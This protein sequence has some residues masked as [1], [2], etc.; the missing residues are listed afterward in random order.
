NVY[1]SGGRYDLATAAYEQSLSIDNKQIES[2]F[3]LGKLLYQVDAFDAATKYY[4]QALI[5]ADEY[6][7]LPSD[8]LLELLA[9]VLA[10][11]F[12]IFQITNGKTNFA[13]LADDYLAVGKT[14]N[15]LA[16]AST[17]STFTLN[18]DDHTSFYPLAEVYMGK[19]SEKYRVYKPKPK[20]KKR[21]KR[22]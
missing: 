13:P 9:N 12:S 6:T 2:A 8:Q 1:E 19:S 7:K 11:S 22:K 3:T 17:N 4:K 5:F 18:P 10:Q 21:K 20:K 16:S 15:Q 14:M